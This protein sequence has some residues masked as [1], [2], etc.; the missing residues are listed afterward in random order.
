MI[1]AELRLLGDDSNS[2]IWIKYD[3]ENRYW[4]YSPFTKTWK[5]STEGSDWVRRNTKHK[6]FINNPVMKCVEQIQL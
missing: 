6:C 4:F 2:G 3:H 5:P 1:K